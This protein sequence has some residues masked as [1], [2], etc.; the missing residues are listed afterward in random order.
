MDLTD[1]F[2][3]GLLSLPGVEEGKSR[4]GPRD[5]FFVAG[6]EFAHVHRDG[7]I[8]LR[9]TRPFIAE[10]REGLEDDSRVLLRRSSDWLTVRYFSAADVRFAL[11]L[12]RVAYEAN[13][14][15]RR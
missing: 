5:A 15:V 4:F 2:A 12:G 13:R 14:S 7:E 1:R 6:R 3:S 11:E 8:D 10:R 9:L